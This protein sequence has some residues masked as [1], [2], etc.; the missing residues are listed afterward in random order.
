[1]AGMIA[2]EVLK[3]RGHNPV[4]FEASDKLAGQF[5]LAGVAPMKQDWADVA[6]WEAKEVERLGIEVRLNTEVTA[7]TIK[8]FNPDNVIIAVGST[9]ALPEIPGIDSPS[10]VSYTHL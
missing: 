1:M 8:E 9:Y 7:E 5:R 4:I 2:A 6:E 3:T 10:A